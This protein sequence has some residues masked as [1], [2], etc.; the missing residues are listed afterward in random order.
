MNTPYHLLTSTATVA[1][2][3]TTADNAG[4]EKLS[5]STAGQ[6]TIPCNI[7]PISTAN[8]M[9]YGRDT[10]TRLFTILLSPTDSAGVDV[11]SRLN[12]KNRIVIGSDTYGMEPGMNVAGQSALYKVIAERVEG[13]HP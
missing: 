13:V 2:L 5:W 6:A 8:N 4:A 7:Q 12:G 1:V 3:S 9:Q 11:L 10:A